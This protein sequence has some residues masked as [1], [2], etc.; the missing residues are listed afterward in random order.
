MRV[1]GKGDIVSNRRNY[2]LLLASQFLSAFGDNFI[3]MLIL[4]PL[5]VSF[6]EGK[7]TPME[8]SV[9]NIFYTSLLMVPFPLLA[10]LT[11]YLNDRFSKNRWLMG[12]NL[13]KVIGTI[14]A[15]L[16]LVSS[17]YWLAI[18]YF[19]VGI[20]AAV[21]SPAKY[22]I[23]PEILPVEDL[24]KAN[25]MVELLTLVAILTGNIAGAMAFDGLNLTLC[26][27]I[28][29]GI[30]LLSLGMNGFMSRTPSYPEVKFSD[31]AGAF[32]H[33]VRALVGER[34]LA[35]VLLGTS[36]FWLCG[37]V[38]KMNFEPWGQQV[39]HLETMTQISLLGLWLA[40]GVMTGS[41]L[42][43]QLYRIGDIHA[44]RRYGWL[45]SAGIACLSGVGWFSTHVLDYPK[46]IAAYNAGEKAVDKYKGIP[47][48]AE[49]R[50]Y[51]S[52]VSKN[53]KSEREKQ[54]VAAKPVD[55]VPAPATTT[56]TYRP[57]LA[58]LGSDGRIYYRTP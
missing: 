37:A 40:L 55:P 44:T 22:G 39:L 20:G 12:G 16:S 27:L 23:L 50:N 4:G 58:S 18:G 30:Y 21:Y 38:L 52:Q 45:L 36:L 2:P 8:Q 33:N 35:L 14:V 43:G 34:R 17:S 25:G 11:G 9:A 24:V 56:E 48:F 15:M 53:L 46:A 5:L 1:N 13:L 29:I 51:V 42:A 49:T 28:L 7:I 32:F 47:P 41:V 57:I 10:P 26:Y 3:L 6:K 31:T 54:K 19:I